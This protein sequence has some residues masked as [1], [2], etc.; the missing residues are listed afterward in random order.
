M[1]RILVVVLLLANAGFWAWREGWLAPL[2]AS[3]GAPPEGDRE[4]ARLAL[5][6]NPERIVPVAPAASAAAGG[7]SSP[8]AAQTAGA[9]GSATPVPPAPPVCLEAGPFDPLALTEAQLA[10]QASLPAS[11]VSVRVLPGGWW[12][13]MGP[14]PEERLFAKKKEELRKRGVRAEEIEFGPAADQILRI[15]RHDTREL[16]QA[17]LEAL[18]TRRVRSAR[19]VDATQTALRV[20]QADAAQQSLLTGLPSAALGGRRFEPC[21][22]EAVEA[23][24]R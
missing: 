22:P 4:P 15:S 21:P 2:H 1:L 16:A 20:A 11:S 9:A 14:Y 6:V 18:G 19:I 23:A 3:L 24:A 10:V 13:A 5:Q 17:E 7:A 8:E 12:V